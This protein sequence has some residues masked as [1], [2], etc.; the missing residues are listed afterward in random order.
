MNNYSLAAA[1]RQALRI[2]SVDT[3]NSRHGQ[4]ACTL[5]ALTIAA[6]AGSPVYSA[7]DEVLQE[8][9][10]TGSRIR[11]ETGMTTPV[12]VT[13]VTTEDLKMSNPG[14]S[15]VDQLDKLPQ[16]FQTESAQRSSGALF[17]N[18]GGSYINLRGLGSQR[19]L[20]LL[21]GSRV[22]QDDRGGTVNIG[23]F[24]TA[25]IK[26]VDI[27]TGGA[28][29]QYGADAVGGVVNFVLDRNFTGLKTSLSTGVT[30]V[31]DGFNH[32][33]SVAGGFKLG[34]KLHVVASA[35]YN[36]I[37]QI[38]RDPTELGSWFSRKGFVTN[39]AFVSAAATPGVPI[40]LTLPN[41]ISSLHS[42]TGRIDTAYP[43]SNVQSAAGVPFT[44]RNSVFLDNGTG[45]RPFVSGAITSGSG[46]TQ[47]MSG[48]PEFGPATAAFPGGP[49]GARV[50]E[51]SGFLGLKYDV[52]DKVSVFGHAMYGSSASD[53]VDQRG[54]PHLQDIWFATI[55]SGNPYL[56]A[57]VQQAMTAQNVGSFKMLKLGQFLGE[58]NWNDNEQPRNEHSMFTWSVGVEADLFADWHLRATWQRGRSHKFTAVYDELRVDRMFLAL[59]AVTVTAANVG[60]SG[61]PIGS[62]TCNVKLTNPTPTQLAASVAGRLN[63]FGQPLLSP[64]GLDAISGCVP[65]NAFGQGNV[66]QAARDYLIGDKWGISNVHQDFAEALLTGKLFEGWAGPVSAAIG[67]TYRAEDFKQRAYPDELERVGPPLNAPAIGIR[68]IPSGFTGGSPNVFQFSTVPPIQGDYD[69]K[70]VFAEVNVPVFKLDSG[71]RLDADLAYRSSR[72]SNVGSV[73][74]YKAGLDF[75]VYSDLRLRG[76]YSRDVRE[77]T[78]AERFDEQGSGGAVNDPNVTACRNLSGNPN[79]AAG[80]SVQITSVAVGNPTLKPEKADTVTLG[81]VFR[82]SFLDGLQMS[83]DYY[84]VNVDGAIGQLG[85]QRIV[86]DCFRN[87]TPAFCAYVERDATSQVI[88][89]VK[90]PYLN[91]AKTTVKGVDYE[92]QYMLHPDFLESLPETLTFRAF[93]SNILKRSNKSSDTAPLNRFDGGFT[94]GVLYPKWKG[95]ASLTY[96]F[97]NWDAQLTEEWIS[98]SKLDT[99]WIDTAAFAAGNTLVNGVT[100]TAPDVDDN[101][102]PNYFNT[103][104]RFGYRDETSSGHQWDV[105]LYVTNLL[106]KHPMVIPSYNSRTG[107]QSVSNNYDAYGRRYV[108]G[109]NFRY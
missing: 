9:T 76:T 24:P 69:V 7:E 52:N 75:T 99:T 1:V 44:L 103:N 98:K 16:L 67:A 11:Q 36:H 8:V 5:S 87:V 49:Y 32:K 48:G 92:A 17:G 15:L 61:L 70:E 104:A 83:V 63:K 35:E 40:R 84:N 71:Q 21:D 59:D 13:S 34:D 54:L 3:S 29:A 68:G 58:D 100:K 25:L 42:P 80:C 56:P 20:V 55:Y 88:G 72:Y 81:A 108:L 57:S 90:N 73:S 14:A 53:Q 33:A 60:T 31:G 41:V 10:I 74:A 19:T 43:L 39:P 12:P 105:S 106:D 86:D 89:R 101:W 18:A 77:A 96:T 102:L 85:F 66:S 109:V 28:S 65:L 107:S 64:V 50:N 30:E 4:L 37:D 62:I 6:L 27:V 46:G 97:G 22:V 23:V 78:F 82:P 95:T 91:V 26:K 45:V 47:S 93:A 94:A 38:L 51:K 2:G 79:A